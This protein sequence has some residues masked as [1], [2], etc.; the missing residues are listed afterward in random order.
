MLAFDSAVNWILLTLTL[1]AANI[2]EGLSFSYLLYTTQVP[3]KFEFPEG[4]WS[5]AQLGLANSFP[6]S[7]FMRAG[8]GY[9][10]GLHCSELWRTI[11]GCGTA[12]V[13]LEVSR[14]RKTLDEGDVVC[15]WRRKVAAYLT[16]LCYI[17]N[18]YIITWH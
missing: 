17:Q 18:K 13:A 14:D 15:F 12:S 2:I 6:S 8:Q 16:P 5:E 1:V 9:S 11:Y 10:S 4:G 7:L 3:E